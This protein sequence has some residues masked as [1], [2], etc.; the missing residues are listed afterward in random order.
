L[1]LSGNKPVPV[2]ILL[3][4]CVLLGVAAALVCCAGHAAFV[5]VSELPPTY[6]C[7]YM[8]QV[9]KEATEFERT[10]AKMTDEEKKEFKNLLLIYRKQCNSALEECRTSKKQ[11]R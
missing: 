2:N 1:I 10:Y 4:V 5:D 11:D 3:S 9:C 8:K 7:E 6:Q